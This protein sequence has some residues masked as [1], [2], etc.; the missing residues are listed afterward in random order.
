[1]KINYN[2]RGEYL[3]KKLVTVYLPIRNLLK[4]AICHNLK[5][6]KLVIEIS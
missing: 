4:L 5:L 2:C 6:S 1:M 3:F